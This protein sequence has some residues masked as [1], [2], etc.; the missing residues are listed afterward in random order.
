VEKFMLEKPVDI[1]LLESDRELATMMDRQLMDS[2]ACTVTHVTSPADAFEEIFATR[3]TLGIISLDGHGLGLLR[4]MRIENDCPVILLAEE[5]SVDEAVEAMRL[6]VVDLFR[7]PFDLSNLIAVARRVTDRELKRR[8]EQAKQR[9]MRRVASR[10]IQD[11]REVHQ[12]MDLI[13][14]DFVQAYRRLAEKVT[15]A[16]LVTPRLPEN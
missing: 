7:K 3:H 11:R 16:G 9:R 4:E 6:G 14:R 13:C 15:E 2:I 8:R 5:V 10:I 1:L 12:R